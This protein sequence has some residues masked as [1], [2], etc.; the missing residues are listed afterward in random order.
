MWGYAQ[1]RNQR[2]A[3]RD[4]VEFL[5][6]DPKRPARIEAQRKVPLRDA[7]AVNSTRWKLWCRLTARFIP[8]DLL[9]LSFSN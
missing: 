5:A 3:N 6:K 9:T 2:K 8:P 4:V 1:R 7:A